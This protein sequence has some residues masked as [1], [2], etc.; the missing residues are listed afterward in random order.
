MIY[1]LLDPDPGGNKS[2]S[3]HFWLKK[4]LPVVTYYYPLGQCL[5]PT[6]VLKDLND[7]NILTD[8]KPLQLFNCSGWYAPN[9]QHPFPEEGCRR[10]FPPGGTERLPG[11]HAG[12]K[13]RDL[14]RSL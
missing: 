1:E 9:G 14:E 13:F 6:R 3:E 4:L 8:Y 11:G 7:K 5:F 10:F 12:E 2:G